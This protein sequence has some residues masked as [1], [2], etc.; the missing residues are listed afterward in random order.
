MEEVRRRS[1]ERIL[2]SITIQKVCTN[3]RRTI[4]YNE[5]YL[6]RSLLK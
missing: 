4:F 2:C 6:R 3:T 5:P 1:K